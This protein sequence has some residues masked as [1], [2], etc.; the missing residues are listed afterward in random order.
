[1]TLTIGIIQKQIESDF[2]KQ[3][4][5]ACVRKVLEVF[6][7]VERKRYALIGSSKPILF[8]IRR[9]FELSGRSENYSPR[10]MAAMNA[11]HVSKCSIP[12]AMTLLRLPIIK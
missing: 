6:A 5:I 7:S 12:Q 11:L 2:L 4:L 9:V 1:M 8:C 10:E 3:L